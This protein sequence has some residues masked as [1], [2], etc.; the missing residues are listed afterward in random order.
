MAFRGDPRRPFVSIGSCAFSPFSHLGVG[1]AASGNK[2]IRE[3]ERNPPKFGEPSAGG[4][5][6]GFPSGSVA[7]RGLPPRR[8]L[9]GSFAFPPSPFGRWE[10]GRLAHKIL[11]NSGGIHQNMV[12][13]SAGY[14]NFGVPSGSV[15]FRDPRRPFVWSVVPHCAA[16]PSWVLR[17]G[18]VGCRK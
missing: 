17:Q 11:D 15:A 8:F 12:D 4:P 6:L 13:A 1:E 9:V 7:C 2:N 14:P 5:N 3:F 18:G 10:K 16:F